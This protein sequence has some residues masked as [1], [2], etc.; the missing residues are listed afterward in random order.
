MKVLNQRRYCVI[1]PCR[2]EAK[3]ARQTL[4][5][6]ANQT[7]RP[8]LWVI[9]DDGSADATPDII[10]EYADAHSFI[11]LLR[12]TDRGYRKVGGGVIDAFYAGYATIDQDQYEFICKL[13]LDLVLPPR[14]FETLIK[15]MDAN[16]R[17]GSVSGKAYVRL[18]GRLVR[19]KLGD[20]HAVGM[21]KF[22]RT[23]CFKEI[24]GFVRELCWDGIDGHRC[25]MRGWMAASCDDPDLR[26]EHLRPM[27]TSDRNWWTGRVRHGV[28]QYFLGTSPMYLLISASYRLVH[29]PIIFGSLAILWGYFKAMMTRCPRYGNPEFRSFLRR[30]Q[31]NCLIMGK[32]RATE[33]LDQRQ[34]DIWLHRHCTPDPDRSIRGG[35][36]SSRSPGRYGHNVGKN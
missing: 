14:Y 25:R 32:R 27:G 15:K 31:W 19:E 29:P 12:V 9:V 23:N 13:D 20:E 24:G 35:H 10:S 30:Y 36:P 22:Y 26:F 17:L 3:F 11:R 5:S 8:S 33:L 16:P 2:D 28:G 7:V 18:G 21:S 6:I 34:L 1:T 4:E